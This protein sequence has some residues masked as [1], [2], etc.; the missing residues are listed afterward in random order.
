MKAE[1]KARARM[2]GFDDCRVTSAEP[3]ATAAHFEK[4]LADGWHGEMEYMQRTAPKRVDPANV[5]AGAKSILG[6]AVSYHQQ[7]QTKADAPTSRVGVV[8]RY[9]RS[10]DYHN[11]VGQRLAQLSR[12]IDALGGPG[13]RSLWYVDTGPLLERDLAQ[14]A[15]VGFIGKHTNV[16]SR[17]LGNWIFLSEIVTTLAIEP[18]E[19]E[20]NYCGSCARCLSACP[21]QAIRAPFQLDARRCIS[22]LTIELKGS[23]PI[24]F[25]KAI[26]NRV[27]GCDDCLEA[28][29]W[30]R[31]A[32]EGRMMRSA[33]K[34]RSGMLDL[35]QLL[36]IDQ[37]DFDRR[38]RGTPLQRTKRRGL[39]RNACVA[40]GNVGSRESLPELEKVRL[41][42]DPVLSEHAAWAIDQINSRRR[43]TE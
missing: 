10:S 23:I 39:L 24:E 14:R 4:W 34:D 11:V 40:L 8:A 22:Y 30:N 38:F 41:S 26:G 2:L 43:A 12:E 13:T 5:L 31:F 7:G 19:P 25:R 16:I 33:V 29:P 36:R 6:L 32:E 28:C 21:T 1:I 20:R 15:G 42:S 18:D 37:A 35:E 17:R 9:A 3:P 27:F